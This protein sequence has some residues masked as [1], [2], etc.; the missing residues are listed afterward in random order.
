MKGVK[1]GFYKMGRNEAFAVF[2]ITFAVVIAYSAWGAYLLHTQASV[3][4][5]VVGVSR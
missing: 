3:S 2:A 5:Q 4:P 1:A